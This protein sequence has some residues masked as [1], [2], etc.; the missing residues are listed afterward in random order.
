MKNKTVVIGIGNP[1][2]QDDR[3]G[4]VVVEKLEALG[5]ACD[6]DIVLTVGFEVMDKVKGYDKAIIVDACML[7]KEPGSILELSVD[8][9]FSTHSLAN[10]HAVTLGTTLKTANMCFPDEMPDDMTLLLIEVKDIKEFTQQ[11]SEPVEKAVD[12]VVER[13]MAMIDVPAVSTIG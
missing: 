2:L 12:Q 10:S 13:I 7:G 11:M 4:V 3:A 1:F 9:I 5:A 8:D 6:T